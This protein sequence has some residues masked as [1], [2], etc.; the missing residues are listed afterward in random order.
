MAAMS[1]AKKGAASAAPSLRE[2]T[3]LAEADQ[4]EADALEA[5]EKVQ[6]PD[7]AERLL[8][9]VKTFEQA[10]RLNKAAADRE[11][12]WRALSL[13][14]LRR[15]GELLGPAEKQPWTGT[16][17]RVYH[18][19]TLSNSERDTRRWARRIA[20]VPAERF[21]E[22]LDG[23]AEPSRTSLLRKS[24]PKKEPQQPSQG[25]RRK[26]TESGQR[27]HALHAERRNGRKPGDLWLMQV[28]VA[29][30]V[31]V[32]ETFDLEGLDWDEE[33]ED[34]VQYVYDDLARLDRWTEHALDVTVAHMDELGRQRKITMLRARAD[35]PSSTPWERENAAR[36]AAKLEEKRNAKQL[37]G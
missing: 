2:Q 37:A 23:N 9:K 21:E 24:G 26:P 5:I 17:Q 6:D 34:L 20:D 19:H 27:R 32:L 28:R 31:G 18:T 12:R 3:E 4:W 11:R 25:K 33:V 14:A 13:R 16:G 36:L 10:M 29:E 35:D 1:R 22:Y 7:E 8:A 30:A 15:Y